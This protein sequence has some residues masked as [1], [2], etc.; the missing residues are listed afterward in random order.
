M[1]ATCKHIGVVKPNNLGLI[2]PGNGRLSGTLKIRHVQY[3]AF[4]ARSQRVTLPR[5]RRLSR[6]WPPRAAGR[7]RDA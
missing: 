5:L 6:P 7:Q 1:Q 4:E 2:A 3:C